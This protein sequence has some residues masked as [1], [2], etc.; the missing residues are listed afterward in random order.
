MASVNYRQS[1][2]EAHPSANIAQILMRYCAWSSSTSEVE[3][4]FSITSALK[5]GSS[6]DLH[7]ARE[8]DILT[9][10]SECQVRSEH[11]ELIKEATEL[12]R[13]TYG[14]SR[15]GCGANVR[16][17]TNSS[18]RKGEYGTGEAAFIRLRRDAAY[19]LAHVDTPPGPATACVDLDTIEFTCEQQAELDF[20]AKNK[21]KRKIYSMQAGHLQPDEIDPELQTAHDAHLKRARENFRDRVTSNRRKLEHVIKNPIEFDG[22]HWWP[23]CPCL[24]AP[25]PDRT[26]SDISD[27]RVF[28]VNRGFGEVRFAIPRD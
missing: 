26:I 28:A 19:A 12:W 8:S 23:E 27:R 2:R 3:R 16:V 15:T 13:N 22:L 1:V 17:D 5:A 10:I 25:D 20:Q 11:D 18:K 14:I 4:G 24:S 7:C 21:L 6:E 9:I